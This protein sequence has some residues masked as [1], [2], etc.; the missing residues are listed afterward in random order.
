MSRSR[1]IILA[2]VLV[3]GASVLGAGQEPQYRT[4]TNTVPIYATVLDRNGRLVTDLTRDD[5]EIFDNGRRQQISNFAS[6]VQP[7]TVVIMLDRSGSV[8]DR[9]SLI[10]NAA[11]E[12]VRKLTDRDK[13]RI[14]S[15]SVRVQIDP[16]TFTSDKDVLFGVLRERLQPMGPTPLWNAT[17]TAMTA[18]ADQPGRRVVLV[19]TDGHDAPLSDQ[20]KTSFEEVRR[21]AETEEIMVYGIGLVSECSPEPTSSIFGPAAGVSWQRGGGGGGQG[22]GGQGRGGRGGRIRLP[23]PLPLPL[24]GGPRMPPR[25]PVSPT[26]R[27]SEESGCRAEGPDPSLRALAEVG[28]GGY[29]ELR[30]AADL[31]STFTRV[32]A[33]LHQQYLLAFVAPAADGAFHQLEVRVRRFGSTVRARRGYVA[34]R[35]E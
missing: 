23:V 29:F 24:P 10:E 34:P 16:E 35:G 32:A 5:F 6:G 1:S 21:R 27:I 11:A 33:E 17:A 15:F 7:I 30:R 28:G 25:V 22:R 13:A 12:F 14:G 18:L 20:P 19:L 26:P 3:C 4:G 31:P 2:I 9:F 8:E